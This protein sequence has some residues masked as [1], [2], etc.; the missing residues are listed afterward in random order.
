MH[1][2]GQNQDGADIS[3]TYPSK[4]I[5]KHCLSPAVRIKKIKYIVAKQHQYGRHYK[6]LKPEKK[7]IVFHTMHE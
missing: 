4:R 2:Q 3:G 6:A 7:T 5:L 1:D